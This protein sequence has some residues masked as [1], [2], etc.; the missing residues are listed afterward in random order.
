VHALDACTPGSAATGARF[1][2][3]EIASTLTVHHAGGGHQG[4]CQ[5]GSWLSVCLI[6]SRSQRF[7]GGRG[8]PARWSGTLA[9]GGERWRAVLESVKAQAFRGFNPTSTATDQARFAT[10]VA[11]LCPPGKLLS[12]F[13]GQRTAVVPGQGHVSC[14]RMVPLAAHPARVG[15][16]HLHR[17]VRRITSRHKCY[18][19]RHMEREPAGPI[20]HYMRLASTRCGSGTCAPEPNADRRA[21]LALRQQMREEPPYLYRV[22]AQGGSAWELRPVRCSVWVWLSRLSVP[23]SCRACDRAGGSRTRAG[24]RPA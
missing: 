22:M 15:L 6:H 23:D 19:G 14:R 12:Q 16:R 7:T 13:F 20:D 9:T 3:Q 2:A 10:L 17:G 1:S 8:P 5:S 24:A 18:R 4:Q 21:W 11:A